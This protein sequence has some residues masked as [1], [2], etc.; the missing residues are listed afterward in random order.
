[1]MTGYAVTAT[2]TTKTGEEIMQSIMEFTDK[3]IAFDKQRKQEEQQLKAALDSWEAQG[4]PGIYRFKVG[5]N[6][7]VIRKN[8]DETFSFVTLGSGL[9]IDH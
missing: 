8:F 2:Q 3:M 5:D 6:P 1:M 7:Y 4:R 9:T